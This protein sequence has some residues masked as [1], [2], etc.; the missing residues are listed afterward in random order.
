MSQ[1]TWRELAAPDLS[2][3]LKGY[4]QFTT[5]LNSALGGAKAT[6]ADI[7][8]KRDASTNNTVQL[9]LAQEQDP[10]KLKAA[11]TNPGTFAGIDPSTLSAA[12][13]AAIG[14]RPGQLL[15]QSNQEL[16]L[17]DNTRLSNQAQAADAAS[18]ILAAMRNAV[19]TGD[20]KAL[21]ALHAANPNVLNG[22]GFKNTQDFQTAI[23]GDAKAGVDLTSSRNHLVYDKEANSRANDANLRGWNEDKRQQGEYGMRQTKFGWETTDRN[24]DQAANAMLANIVE[25]SDPNNKE[26]VRNAIF[27]G[28]LASADPRIRALVYSRLPPALAGALGADELA[29]GIGAPTGVPDIGA[30]GGNATP[31]DTVVGNGQYGTPSKPLSSMSMG[32]VYNFGRNV[33]IPQTK[34]AGV[35]R[36]PDGRLLGSS[37]S[38]TFQIT[39]S[40]LKAYAPRVL[41][42][43]WQSKPFNAAN[44]DKIAEAIFNDNKGSASKLMSTWASLKPGVAAQL[45]GKDWSQARGIIAQG[46]TSAS[47]KSLGIGAT[48]GVQVSMALRRGQE[49][50]GKADASALVQAGSVDSNPNDVVAQLRAPGSRFAGTDP[51]F[52]RRELDAIVSQ[53]TVKDR[54]GNS[55]QRINYAQA[56][57]LLDRHASA[58]TGATSEWL[59]PSSWNIFNMG[60]SVRVNKQ[61]DRINRTALANDIASLKDPNGLAARANREQ[62]FNTASATLQANQAAAAKAYSDLN[63]LLMRLPTQPGL[64]PQVQAARA[65]YQAMQQIL[66][67]SQQQVSANNGTT[68]AMPEQGYADKARQMWGDLTSGRLFS[69]RRQ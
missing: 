5:L 59:H 62:S 33:L 19:F 9:A 67:A 2:G 66:G 56:A 53:G 11:L 44:Q 10:E 4:N 38:G 39:G 45:V 37:A 50:Q 40:T 22:I 36:T 3:S 47:A 34:A 68:P 69:I 28:P 42:A 48:P 31:W 65:K 25:S 64:A 1:L 63:A 27:N 52:V 61:G 12:T 32:E 13:I 14:S 55:V 29:S 8:A 6:I 35:G 57:I 17:K 54:N 24:V 21:D 46:E 43:D 18:P 60:N 15:T 16:A 51:G 26:S 23:Q 58:N 30:G 20:T 41:G 49:V 7:G